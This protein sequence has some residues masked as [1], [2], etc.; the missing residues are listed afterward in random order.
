MSNWLQVAHA[1][2]CSISLPRLIT[3]FFLFCMFHRISTQHSRHH[4]DLLGTNGSYYFFSTCES[5]RPVE[6]QLIID[7]ETRKLFSWPFLF[8]FS[9]SL[10]SSFSVPLLTPV[11]ETTNVHMNQMS[12][13]LDGCNIVFTYTTMDKR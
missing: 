3:C 5:I 9:P 4:V 10:S 8:F 12:H 6:A 2:G 11:R 7:K 13:L 1:I